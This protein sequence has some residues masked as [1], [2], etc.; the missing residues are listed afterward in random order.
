MTVGSIYF[1]CSVNP[2]Y[3]RLCNSELFGSKGNGVYLC[4]FFG[5]DLDN[6]LTLPIREIS[7][8]DNELILDLGDWFSFMGHFE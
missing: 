3:I 5:R 1:A 2:V 4:N 7:V 6:V 8:D